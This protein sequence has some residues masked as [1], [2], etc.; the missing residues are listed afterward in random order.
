M[1][2]QL[3]FGGKASRTAVGRSL[4]ATEQVTRRLLRSQEDNCPFLEQLDI[5][6]LQVWSKLDKNLGM[7]L[8]LFFPESDFPRMCTGSGAP[9][10]YCIACSPPRPEFSTL[11]YMTGRVRLCNG[12]RCGLRHNGEQ[13]PKS[14]HS[15]YKE[16][17]LRMLIQ[18]NIGIERFC[19]YLWLLA[20]LTSVVPA[21]AGQLDIS[22]KC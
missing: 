15:M 3:C 6:L 1:K 2:Q 9:D 13:T 14:M 7:F 4:W 21:D 10:T 11:H 12:I 20:G 17:Q 19:F 5:R 22:E 18:S 8:L 16:I